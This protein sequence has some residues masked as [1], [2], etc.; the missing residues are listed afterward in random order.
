VHLGNL[1]QPLAAKVLRHPH[2]VAAQ[3]GQMIRKPLPSEDRARGRF[4]RALRAFQHKHVVG[5][6]ARFKDASHHCNEEHRADGAGTGA[7][8]G[9]EIGTEPA[10]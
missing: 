1:D 10:M 4:Q 2:R 3:L 5:L 9:A 8:L 7:M 6:A